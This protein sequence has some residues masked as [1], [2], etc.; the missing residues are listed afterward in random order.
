MTP[1][2]FHTWAEML[3]EPTVLAAGDGRVLAANRALERELGFARSDLI[4]RTL[5]ELTT[6]QAERVADYL[7]ACSRSRDLVP[8]AITLSAGG[9]ELP[10][11]C[12]GAVVRPADGAGPAVLLLR[13]RS[14][15]SA[16]AQFLALS[17]KIEELAKEVV[18]RQRSEEALR[19]ADRLKNEFLGTLAHELRNPL[20]PIANSL[21]ILRLPG[22][23]PERDAYFR[24]VIERQ[25]SEMA[26]MVGDLVEVARLVRDR[27]ELHKERVDIGTVVARGVE[28]ARP[29][30]DACRHTLSVT[31]P[32]EPVWL[33]A[34]PVRLGQVVANLLNN[35]ANY[36]DE[37]GRIDLTV[38]AERGAGS[39]ELKTDEG[40]SQSSVHPKFRTPHSAF[41]EI[42][43][44]DSGIG[45]PADALGRIFEPFVH[46]ERVV[47]RCVGGLGVGLSLV[48][49]YVEMHGGTIEAASPGQGQGSTFTV[50]LPLDPGERRA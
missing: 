33:L 44:S 13:L 19:E 3:P 12:E 46:E 5:A 21:E 41:V 17:V 35:A 9:R 8:G 50:R 4:D 30:I 18:R 24:G 38:S 15:A 27:I 34:D 26:R 14:Q 40:L 23:S 2:E 10:C 16:S 32:P 25:V 39:A 28:T 7:R 45:I 42:R 29:L 31:L 1:A 22:L 49:R 43:V 11:R 20:A 36:T 37:G 47:G 6:D 48:K